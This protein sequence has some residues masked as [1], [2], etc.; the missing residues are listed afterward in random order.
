[1]GNGKSGAVQ[2][3]EAAGGMIEVKQGGY[4]R[5]D[6]GETGRLQDGCCDRGH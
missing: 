5:D 6:E 4:R 2:N 3:S 1:M